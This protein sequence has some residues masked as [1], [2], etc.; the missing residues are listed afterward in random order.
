[1]LG[2]VVLLVTEILSLLHA[3][4][5]TVM[6]VLWIA[7]ATGTALVVFLTHARV[8][9]ATP[10]APANGAGLFPRLAAIACA[11][12]LAVTFLAAVVAPPNYPDS[13]TY[14]MSRV[15]HW[16]QERSLDWYPT[17][18]PRQNY[19]MPFAEIVILHLQLLSGG[20]RW[21]NLVQ[22]GAL[23]LAGITVSLI[24]AE[25]GE[26]TRV[27][28]MGALVAYTTPMAVLQATG[29]QN[30]VVVS[31][32][33]LVFL[34]FLWRA[35]D[36]PSLR[37]AAPCGLALGL[38]L[39]TKGTAYL[40]A[41]AMAV[42]LVLGRVATR[43][44]GR[45]P[46]VRGLA[47]AAILAVG[48]NL[49]TWSRGVSAT[50]MPI[51]CGEFYFVDRLTPGDAVTNVLRN[52]ASHLGIPGLLDIVPR[53]VE[54]LSPADVD[55]PAITFGREEF[56]VY[57]SLHEGKAGNTLLLFGVVAATVAIVSDRR[58]R[59]GPALPWLAAAAAGFLAYSLALKWQPWGSRLHTPAF[60]VAG[61]PI[62]FALGGYSRRALPIG[63]IILFLGALPYLLLNQSRPLIG[64][65]DPSILTVPRTTQYYVDRKA[66][67]RPYTAT[68][69]FLRSRAEEEIGLL[70]DG[71]DYEYPFWLAVKEDFA[72]PPRIRH[73]GVSRT[74]GGEPAPIPPAV[75]VS[76]RPGDRQIVEGIEYVRVRDFGE[77]SILRRAGP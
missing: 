26:S 22:W 75:V 65:W 60:L 30:D 72:G 49:G 52:A 13:M 43:G 21:A 61:I 2:A 73:V 6:I 50:G 20:D 28:W 40:Y 56:V 32:W 14:H 12:I 1:M 23:A 70:L 41:P 27:Q 3:V 33:L 68:A 53:A 17:A 67:R 48:V 31:L 76:S 42:A 66:Y 7:L 19:Q 37:N 59:G 18:D 77:L 51:C 34:L 63:A 39:A 16:I 74:P 69:A 36:D 38:A 35:H 47:F 62:T 58:L 29:A 4:T 25:L 44:G 11:T 64:L 8:A 55:D 57:Y 46:P 15:A 45:M 9:T 71:N 5:R 24:L 10:S 54:F